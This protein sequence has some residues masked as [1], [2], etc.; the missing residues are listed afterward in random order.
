V[1]ATS[2]AIFGNMYTSQGLKAEDVISR[3]SFPALRFNIYDGLE[4]SA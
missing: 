1:K 4:H 2:I 3:Y